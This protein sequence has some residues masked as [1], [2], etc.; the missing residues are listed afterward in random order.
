[1][2]SFDVSDPNLKLEGKFFIEASAGCGKTFSM[3]NAYVRLIL[4][5]Q[6]E[7]KVENILV[8]TFTKEATLELKARIRAALEKAKEELICSKIIEIGYLK[9]WKE[10]SE[11]KRKKLIYK[12]NDALSSFDLA[13][14]YTIHK[15]CF[16]KL[17]EY[18][19]EAGIDL[20]QNIEQSKV[21]IKTYERLVKDYLSFGYGSQ[22]MSPA[23]LKI[24]LSYYK[25]NFELLLK[26]C[27][28]QLIKEQPVLETETYQ[29][30]CAKCS[31]SVEFFQ[32]N[33]FWN[34][35][36]IEENLSHVASFYK[37]AFNRQNE[38]NQ[39]LLKAI[40]SLKKLFQKESFAQALEEFLIHYQV[41]RK[42]FNKENL[43]KSS[44]ENKKELREFEIF[45]QQLCP[46]FDQGTSKEGLLSLL[47]GNCYQ[48][49]LSFFKEHK[50]LTPNNILEKF[51]QL[52][53]NPWIQEQI[54]GTY[55]AVIIDE[56]QDTDPLQWKI[57]ARLFLNDPSAK[58]TLFVVGDPKQSIYGFRKAD[59]YTYLNAA[60]MM[61]I[62]TPYS[63]NVN[64]RSQPDLILALNNLFEKI[65]N[66]WIKLPK[67]GSHLTYQPV[68]SSGTIIKK[69]FADGKGSLHFILAETKKKLTR[70]LYEKLE[71][72]L[73][74]PF[75]LDEI[76]KLKT[77]PEISL[78]KIAVLV[79]DRFQ[80]DRLKN[81]LKLASIP[82]STMRSESLQ[83]KDSVYQ[84]LQIF[85]AT[86]NP[87]QLRLI[88]A[89]K[90]NTLLNWPLDC[91]SDSHIH[92]LVQHFSHL[93]TLLFENGFLA[94]FNFLTYEKSLGENSLYESLLSQKEGI[95]LYQELEQ[96][97]ELMLE[98][99]NLGEDPYK[100]YRFLE[101]LSV[102]NVFAEQAYPI[103]QDFEE[104]G[105]RILTLHMSKG[106]EFEI[107]FAL[108]LIQRT[109]ATDNL[110]SH[111]SNVLYPVSRLSK[112]EYDLYIQEQNAEKLRTLYVA[113]TRAKQ[114]LYL[115][116]FFTE[117]NPSIEQTSPMEIFLNQL[118]LN[119]ESLKAFILAHGEMSFSLLKPANKVDKK[120]AFVPSSLVLPSATRLNYPK[121]YKHSFSSLSSPLQ[122]R[123]LLNTPQD[124]SVLKKNYHT[125]PAGAK[126]G[127]LIHEILESISFNQPL[128]IEAF[129]SHTAYEPWKEVIS[130]LIQDILVSPITIQERTF[131]LKDLPSNQI[132]KEIEFLYPAEG[133]LEVEEMELQG[134]LLHGFIDLV[135]EYDQRYYIIDYKT[136]WLGEND[137]SY[138]NLECSMLE[139][140]YFLQAKIYQE[141]LKK[142][143]KLFKK[144]SIEKAS[145]GGVIYWFVR[146]IHNENKGLF[147][148]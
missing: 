44:Q 64:Y 52:I 108:G 72:E 13:Q 139:H 25:G 115:P 85:E 27:V 122:K 35:E 39:D 11:Q 82:F 144:E 10:A 47:V 49:L 37:G 12:L 104:E 135:V 113:L 125:L 45:E 22:M 147:I 146:G 20:A 17:K 101:E 129:V 99:E 121:Y 14:I 142:Y 1:M 28:E 5:S 31:Q 127:S 123:E 98:K 143:L 55:P 78:N 77:H 59:I 33:S 18:L 74:F 103:R 106:L 138:F 97:K 133:T 117:D 3:E 32:K 95:S 71:E 140:Q 145:L 4:E 46:L 110:I 15:F 93:K 8:L 58:R 80:A 51:S 62:S 36:N 83:A 105:V 40:Q 118:S 57:L 114:R 9:K 70:T 26:A 86:L 84:F 2:K 89:L 94:F 102:E 54:A 81:V 30:F 29:E 19:F 69:D 119:Q 87:N 21:S 16:L 7:L 148:F 136:N 23:Q 92:S 111:Q 41:F 24:L 50:I 76:G 124:F 48:L 53:M 6:A 100:L 132:H 66:Q 130:N 42:V 134:D 34:F 137:Q 91:F 56:F 109:S 63:L 38:I 43:K 79:K 120:L 75:I 131:C 68:H 116:C 65:N 112:E 107:V 128:N 60:Q 61:G 90:I 73:V 96:V 88:R 141:A 67:N 126:T